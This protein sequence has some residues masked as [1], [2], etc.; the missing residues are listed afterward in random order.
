MVKLK[1]LTQKKL[2]NLTENAVLPFKSTDAALNLF[3]SK[4]TDKEMNILSYELKHSIRPNFINKTD[5]LSTFDFIHRSMSKDLK[6]QK[7]TEKVKTKI[8]YLVNTYVNS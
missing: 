1:I 7:D 8:S 2:C 4:L 6:D 5:I 3:S